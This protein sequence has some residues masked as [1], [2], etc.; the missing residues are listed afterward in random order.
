MLW[1]LASL[2]CDGQAPE[3]PEVSEARSRPPC[4]YPLV[5]RDPSAKETLWT[6]ATMPAGAHPVL[7][8]SREPVACLIPDRPGT[9]KIAS[10]AYNGIT[11]SDVRW[12]TIEVD[13]RS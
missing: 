2:A 9:Y 11:W 8:G 1:L 13:D 4:A 7:V 12:H 6:I 5:S 10:A 3:G